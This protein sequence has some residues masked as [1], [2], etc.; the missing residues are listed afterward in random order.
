MD[1]FLRNGFSLAILQSFGKKPEEMEI[2]HISA[3][4]FARMFASSFKNL[5]EILSIPAAFEISIHCKIPQ[6]LFSVVKVRLKLSISF[7]LL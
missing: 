3:I 6:T 2:L 5:P 7:I 4:G 1:P